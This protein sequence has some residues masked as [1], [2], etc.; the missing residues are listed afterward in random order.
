MN[1][2]SPYLLQTLGSVWVKDEIKVNLRQITSVAV[3]YSDVCEK[4]WKQSCIIMLAVKGDAKD[5]M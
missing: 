3:A 1:I 4:Q 5:K 2:N